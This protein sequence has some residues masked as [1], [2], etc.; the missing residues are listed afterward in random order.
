MNP[1]YLN[2]LQQNFQA[3]QATKAPTATQ[4]AVRTPGN[5]ATHLLPV[6]GSIL[7]G[8]VG[9]IPGAAVGGGLGKL[10]ENKLE[11]Q[12]LT[13]GVAGQAL[14][15]GVGEGVGQVAAPIISKAISPVTGLLGRL[16]G[17]GAEVGTQ[18][19][20]QGAVDAGAQGA[21]DV[22]TKAADVVPGSSSSWLDRILGRDAPAAAPV[23]SQGTGAVEV[24]TGG[25]I[26]SLTGK[27]APETTQATTQ[28]VAKAGSKLATAPTPYDDAVT[29]YL[30]LKGLTT[31]EN[32][33]YNKGA[34]F[35]ASPRNL[36][37]AFR[38][39]LKAPDMVNAS[40]KLLDTL[41]SGG[42][43]ADQFAELPAI[44]QTVTNDLKGVLAANENKVAANNLIDNLNKIP[45]SEF[46]IQSLDGMTPAQQL[47]ESSVRNTPGSTYSQVDS[48]LNKAGD[49]V[50]RYTDANGNI[51]ASGLLNINQE[52]GDLIK[53]AQWNALRGIGDAAVTPVDQANFKIW[54]ET[55]QALEKVSPEASNILKVQALT[56]HELPKALQSGIADT[57]TARIGVRGTMRGGIPGTAELF[58]KA[59]SGLG[60][61]L[62]GVGGAIPQLGETASTVIP[63]IL[64]HDI[65]AASDK[66][67]TQAI[68]Q[69]APTPD[70]ANPSSDIK[71]TLS[72]VDQGSPLGITPEQIK[73]AEMVDLVTTGGKNLSSL[74]KI[75]GVVNATQGNTLS[76][77]G[78]KSVADY[79]N[80]LQALQGLSSTFG[81]GADKNQ[82]QQTLTE[83]IPTLTKA[84]GL[85]KKD[86]LTMLPTATDNQAVVAQ[87][88]SDIKQLIDSKANQTIQTSV[89][90][91]SPDSSSLIASL[92][93]QGA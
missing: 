21:T 82:V 60:R 27:A 37:Q 12:N 40:N 90:Q 11:K 55:R 61:A 70:L 10:G 45:A 91:S 3:S 93:G 69:A 77:S 81:S 8:L 57:G 4:A 6:A 1:D 5:W 25:K 72:G 59:Q 20:T 38:G 28:L 44:H 68:N 14:L 48:A 17:R 88:L 86:L 29:S 63:Q 31:P 87:K 79:Q 9:S 19:A 36:D 58:Q 65:G 43:V 15:G 66:Q 75:S 16:L 92:L 84:T 71:T 56:G 85:A 64:G 26:V 46:N 51:S 53:P 34:E 13:S 24:G 35:T 47:A 18:A 54:Q 23:V 50:K 39:S 41:G 76:S 7:G 22:A 67:A 32:A 2:Q 89:T 42:A 49:I 80:S 30:Q 33:L 74:S 78:T 73:Q 62:Q 52:V 83:A